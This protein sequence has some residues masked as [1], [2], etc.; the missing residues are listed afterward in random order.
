MVDLLARAGMLKEAEKFIEEEIGGI[1]KADAN[2]WGAL[3]GAC[4]TYG[5][6]EIGNR[7]WKKLAG[8]GLSDCG[9]HVLSYNIL[10]EAGWELEARRVR[11]FIL[12]EG[13][14]KKPGGSVIEVNDVVEEFLAGDLSHTQSQQICELLD[15]LS[16]MLSPVE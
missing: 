6:V 9:V 7:V 4:R 5:N 3:L 13:M 8:M 12:E 14:K 1:E 10:R 11:R 15:S 2:V 16:N